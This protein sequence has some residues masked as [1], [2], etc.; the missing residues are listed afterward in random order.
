M[1]ITL[2]LNH[3]SLGITSLISGGCFSSRPVRY[4]PVPSGIINTIININSTRVH[5][6]CFV[7]NWHFLKK[8]QNAPRPSE[9]SPVRGGK[10]Q[11]V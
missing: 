10:C 3:G 5:V 7:A 2:D 6:E 4:L 11:N 9:H 1:K 8:I